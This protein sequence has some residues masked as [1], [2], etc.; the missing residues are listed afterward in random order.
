MT[1]THDNHDARRMQLR[2]TMEA[3]LCAIQAGEALVAEHLLKAAKEAED[4]HDAAAQAADDAAMAAEQA[5]IERK[6]EAAYDRAME[7]YIEGAQ[8]T[9]PEWHSRAEMWAD[10]E[11]RP[12]PDYDRDL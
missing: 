5:E 3:A 8:V 9:R 7:R 4:E 12:A 2:G 11:G 1:I 6:D 10:L